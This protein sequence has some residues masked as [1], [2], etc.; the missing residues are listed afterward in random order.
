MSKKFV[1]AALTGAALMTLAPSSAAAQAMP[2]GAELQE[3]RVDMA[4]GAMNTLQF[5]PDGTVRILSSSGMEVA[6]GRWFVQ[7]Q[8][9]CLELGPNA[10]ECWPYRAAF[11]AYQAATL[12][13]DCGATSQWTALSTRQAAPPPPEP[14]RAGERG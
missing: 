11:Q 13:S 12:T 5:Q 6:Q 8:M 4:N 7:N 2:S 3:V 1:A 9:L 14:R 10:R